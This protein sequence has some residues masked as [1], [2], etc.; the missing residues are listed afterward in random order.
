M[1]TMLGALFTD[2]SISQECLDLALK[3]AVDRSF[4]AISVDGDTSTNDTL[5]I[6]ANGAAKGPRLSDPK[7]PAFEQFCQILT[8]FSAELAQL[9]V[10]D[11]EGATKFIEIKV[12]VSFTIFLKNR[13]YVKCVFAYTLY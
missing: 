4:N 11:G 5:A 7:S 10:R 9:I 8:E 12:K 13:K 3:H 6:Y 1:A 2:L